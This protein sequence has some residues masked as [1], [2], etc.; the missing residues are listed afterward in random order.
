M[1]DQHSLMAVHQFLLSREVGVMAPVTTSD[2]SDEALVQVVR[3]Q[4]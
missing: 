3:L 2:K 1:E 4:V